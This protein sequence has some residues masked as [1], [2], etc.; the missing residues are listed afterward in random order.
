MGAIYIG[1]TQDWLVGKFIKYHKFATSYGWTPEQ[2]DN[3]DWETIEAL[4][5]IMDEEGKKLEAK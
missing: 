5:L 2:V 4:D 3:M 1:Y